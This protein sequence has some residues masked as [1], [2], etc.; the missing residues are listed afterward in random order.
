ML[1][2]AVLMDLAFGV[3]GRLHAQLQLLSLAFAVKM[4]VALAFLASV[5]TLFPS[6]FGKIGAAT[7]AVLQKLLIR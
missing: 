1:A 3:L 6:V 4:L 2:L 5:S 7:F